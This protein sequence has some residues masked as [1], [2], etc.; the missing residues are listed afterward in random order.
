MGLEGAGASRMP[1][2]MSDMGA[3][4]IMGA[5]PAAPIEGAGAVGLHGFGAMMS[6]PL[7]SLT[8]G[9][10]IA[11]ASGPCRVISYLGSMQTFQYGQGRVLGSM[12]FQRVRMGIHS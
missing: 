12:T 7:P 2:A 11:R 4:P 6:T 3:M 9:R 1:A 8:C 10:G 5:M